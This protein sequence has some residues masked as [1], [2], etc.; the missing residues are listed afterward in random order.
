VELIF[1][2]QTRFIAVLTK[3]LTEKKMPT[4]LAS[5]EVAVPRMMKPTAESR[6]KKHVNGPRILTLSDMVAVMIMTKKQSKYGGADRPLDVR[7][8]KVPSSEMMVG[9]NKGREAKLTLVLKFIRAK[10]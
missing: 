7:V 2:F 3:M 1:V 9:R 6:E 5:T 10:K 8:E 4:Y